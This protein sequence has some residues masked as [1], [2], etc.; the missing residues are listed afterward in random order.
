MTYMILYDLTISLFI[1]TKP[2]PGRRSPC[3]NINIHNIKYSSRY[4]NTKTRE[5]Q[6]VWERRAPLGPQHVRQLVKKGIKVCIFTSTKTMNLTKT[7]TVGQDGDQG[8][9][10]PSQHWSWIPICHIQYSLASDIASLIVN[11]FIGRCWCSL[12]TDVPTP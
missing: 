8:L 11:I 10:F 1:S 12:P 9:F 4:R 2:Q 7:K 5:T 6:S 3:V